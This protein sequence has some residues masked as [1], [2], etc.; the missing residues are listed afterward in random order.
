MQLQRHIRLDFTPLVDIAL[1]LVLAY[2]VILYHQKAKMIDVNLP[3]LNRSCGEYCF[4]NR[5][6]EIELYLYQDHIVYVKGIGENTT[7]YKSDYS[8]KEFRKM[9]KIDKFCTDTD[10][11]V[12]MIKPTSQSIYGNLVTTINRFNQ[13]GFKRFGLRPY[14]IKDEEQMLSQAEKMFF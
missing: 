2:M 9:L 6:N 14:L 13:L 8:L 12:V 7:V 4:H 11:R 1:I 5:N 10:R 3:E